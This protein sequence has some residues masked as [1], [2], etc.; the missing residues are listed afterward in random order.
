MM[1]D[2]FAL[3]HGATSLKAKVKGLYQT[4]L[5][6][7]DGTVDTVVH[8]SIFIDRSPKIDREDC[9]SSLTNFKLVQLFI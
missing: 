1:S 8:T 6:N 5:K 9:R 7:D 3:E 2:L 4:L